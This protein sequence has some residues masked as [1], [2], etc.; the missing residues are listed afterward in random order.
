MTLQPINKSAFTFVSLFDPGVAYQH[1]PLM[2]VVPR[3][4][5]VPA[6]REQGALLVHLHFEV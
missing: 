2:V 4:N 6:L 5:L 1:C 3:I